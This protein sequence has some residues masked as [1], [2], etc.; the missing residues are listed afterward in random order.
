M[1]TKFSVHIL[2]W[3][4]NR[5]RKKRVWKLSSRD[6]WTGEIRSKD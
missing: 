4:R 2:M 5:W 6:I 1:K 3:S